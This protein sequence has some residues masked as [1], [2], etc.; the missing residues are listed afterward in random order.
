VP[1]NVSALLATFCN[2]IVA[3]TV[4]TAIKPPAV[5]VTSLVDKAPVIPK[6]VPGITV[7]FK[8]KAHTAALLKSPSIVTIPYMSY[9]P[10]SVI[11]TALSI[12]STF[13]FKLNFS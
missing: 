4:L 9:T 1:G 6:V 10:G 13:F 8:V 11:C 2:V 7:L 5:K 3:G 12:C